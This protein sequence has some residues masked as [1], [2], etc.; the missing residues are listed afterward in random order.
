MKKPK[1][2]GLE[3]P[4]SQFLRSI[5]YL[6]DQYESTTSTQ[7]KTLDVEKKLTLLNI[8][9]IFDDFFQLPLPHA[10]GASFFGAMVSPTSCGTDAEGCNSIGVGGRG[11][12]LRQAFESCVGEAA[13]YLSMIERTGDPLLVGFEN[14][15][16]L[17]DEHLNWALD[18]A[19][20]PSSVNLNSLDWVKA[21]SLTGEKSVLFP[22]EMIIRRPEKMRLGRRQAESSGVAAG[23]THD[24]A[25]MSALMEVIERDAIGL[26]WFGRN[27]GHRISQDFIRECGF[28]KFAKSIRKDDP[29]RWWLLD[30]TSDI[31]VPVVAALSSDDKG[32]A[33]VA[34]FSAR[35]SLSAAME[36]AFLEMCQMELA[37]KI[38]LTKY[39]HSGDRSLQPTDRLWLDRFERLTLASY[40]ELEGVEIAGTTS[41]IVLDNN[42]SGMLAFLKKHRLE[43]YRVDL[44]RSEIG[45]PVTRVLVPGLQSSKIDWMSDRLNI[46]MKNNGQSLQTLSNRPSPI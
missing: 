36:S 45:I 19:G 16:K 1:L 28:D 33:V 18:G 41:L 31:G 5:E 39:N 23:S 25:I 17:N 21:E 10:P 26:W 40:P 9:S 22:S 24:Q 30:I 14:A 11:I 44:T 8:A 15:S 37:Q 42:V 27:E 35:N 12:N 38:T 29:H 2:I 6:G 32:R 7:L 3:S 13:E 4:E 20:L 43:V 46:T 34:G